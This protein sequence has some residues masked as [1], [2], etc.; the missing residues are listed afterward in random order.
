MPSPTTPPPVSMY[1]VANDTQRVTY[2]DG[3]WVDIPISAWQQRPWANI[4]AEFYCKANT[5]A[6][7][8]AGTPKPTPS[9]TPPP[10]PPFTGG[11][12]PKPRPTPGPPGSNPVSTKTP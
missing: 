4:P 1:P 12:I 7:P 3:K 11:F 9:P 5:G 2:A 10:K 8:P 6:P